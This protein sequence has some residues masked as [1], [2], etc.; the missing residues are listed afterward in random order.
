MK[1]SLIL[2]TIGRKEEICRLFDSL[3]KQKYNNLEVI[4]VD[5]NEPGYLSEVV[6]K[7][8][9]FIDI[10]HIYSPR[11]LSVARNVGLKHASGD[12]YCFPDDDCWYYPDTLLKVKDQLKN[13]SSL[14]GVT[15]R[16]VDENGYESVAKFGAKDTIIDRINVF[17]SA[18]SITLFVR[19]NTIKF[20]ELIGA[21]ADSIY[22][23]G[24]ETDYVLSLLECGYVLR[25]SPE[26][27]VGHPN[28]MTFP[29]SERA[30]KYGCGMGYLLRTHN[31]SFFT[32][33]KWCIKPLLGTIL[34]AFRLDLN[35]SKFYVYTLVGR[36]LGFINAKN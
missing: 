26:L 3:S 32:V 19:K 4:L 21:G 1:F 24:E 18:V 5:Q 7:Y 15:G 27:V 29:S 11:G 13:N 23:S 31:Y 25:Y 36:I 6:D 20:N 16:C 22:G 2:A 9:S 17:S 28:V 10:K 14:F 12:I 35:R 34:Y 8:T 33:V 30:F